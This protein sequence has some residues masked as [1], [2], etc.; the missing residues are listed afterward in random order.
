MNINVWLMTIYGDTGVVV[1]EFDGG[2]NEEM[3]NLIVFL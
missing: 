2:S 1:E 3:V